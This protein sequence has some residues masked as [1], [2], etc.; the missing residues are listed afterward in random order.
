MIDG[1]CGRINM[2][3]DPADLVGELEID[4]VSYAHRELYNVPPGGTLPII[5]DRPDADGVIVRRL[6]PARWGLV[7]GWAKDVKIGFRAFNARSETVRS[8]PMFRSAF[9]RQRTV[10]PVPAYYEWTAGPDGKEPWMMRSAHHDFLFM[11][12]LYEFRRL[13]EE[14][15]AVAGDDP[16]A[17]TGWLVTTTILTT[18]AQ[19]HL[20]EVH[21]RMPVMMPPESIGDW[22]APETDA[23]GA[24]EVLAQLLDASDPDAVTRFR[25]GT[26]VGN[27]RNQGAHLAQPLT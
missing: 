1:M 15:Q 21:D 18:Q 26:E 17:A 24:A 7:P 20:A 14:Q 19:G 13:T 12:G 23:D 11:A 4:Q 5:V 6:E 2:G 16:A 25:V 8:K 22:T 3:L 9:A 10:V 27:V